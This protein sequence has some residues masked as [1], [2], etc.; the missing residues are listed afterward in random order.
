MP[1]KGWILIALAFVVID[2]HDRLKSVCRWIV[3]RG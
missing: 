1:S 2:A 3:R